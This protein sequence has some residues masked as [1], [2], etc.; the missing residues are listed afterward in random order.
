MVSIIWFVLAI[1]NIQLSMQG[2]Y[3]FI[4]NGFSLDSALKERLKS[5]FRYLFNGR[6]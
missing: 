5:V 6:G 1:G 2:K 3:N 4:L